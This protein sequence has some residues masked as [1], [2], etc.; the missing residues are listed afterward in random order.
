MFAGLLQPAHL[1]VLLLIL[2]LVMGP[3]RLRGVG[4][5]LGESVRALVAGFREGSQ[6]AA[7]AAGDAPALPARP[8]PRCGGWSVETA[9]FCTRCG[10][11]LE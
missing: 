2:L 9:A 1:V 4:R 7:R 10:T 11:R 6:P 8:C 5:A 3:G